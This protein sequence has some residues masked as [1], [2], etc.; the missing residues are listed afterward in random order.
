[1]TYRVAMPSPSG[2]NREGLFMPAPRGVSAAYDARPGWDRGR[3]RDEEGESDEIATRR[4]LDRHLARH[5]D[6]DGML[7]RAG[8]LVD[9]HVEAVRSNAQRGEGEDAEAAQRGQE[10]LEQTGG[11]VDRRRM[12]MDARARGCRSQLAAIFAQYKAPPRI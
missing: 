3:A 1:M 9:A 8:Q 12:G 7:Q 5:I 10:Q 11:A 2:G 4:D 6:D